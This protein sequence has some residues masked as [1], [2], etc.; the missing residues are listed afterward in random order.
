MSVDG[1]E[2][3]LLGQVEQMDIQWK[4][5]SSK[6]NQWGKGGSAKDLSTFGTLDAHLTEVVDVF[7]ARHDDEK[8][9]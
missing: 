1:D 5:Y 9:E 8:E 4:N 3:N 2:K 7:E 6:L